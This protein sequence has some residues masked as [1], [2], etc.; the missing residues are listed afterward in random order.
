VKSASRPSFRFRAYSVS[1]KKISNRRW[2]L[3]PP[4]SVVS[5]RVP[6]AFETCG[7][8]GLPLPYGSRRSLTTSSRLEGRT[9]STSVRGVFFEHSDTP[10][11]TQR[12]TLPRLDWHRELSMV[13]P[14]LPQISLTECG[15]HHTGGHHAQ[16]SVPF[17]AGRAI[18]VARGI[19]Y[20]VPE[21]G[22]QR[23]P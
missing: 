20:G 23:R 21:S 18:G 22:D 14:N 13:S 12:A 16:P 6:I 5:G 10:Y 8:P 1:S 2:Y 9:T 4:I 15:G 19:A 7:L 11:A 17:A 3:L